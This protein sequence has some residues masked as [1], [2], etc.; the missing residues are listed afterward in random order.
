MVVLAVA[1]EFLTQTHR[2]SLGGLLLAVVTAMLSLLPL[3]VIWLQL[4]LKSEISQLRAQLARNVEKL[5]AINKYVGNRTT[6]ERPVE[7]DHLPELRR[8]DL[9]GHDDRAADAEER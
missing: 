8:D 9:A 4:K 5:N 6:D 3:G 7:T 1:G 2:D